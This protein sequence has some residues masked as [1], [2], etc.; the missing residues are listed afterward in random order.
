MKVTGHKTEAVYRRYAIV[1]E[2]D[3]RDAG[4]KLTAVLGTTPESG[5]LNSGDNSVAAR[6]A[7]RLNGWQEWWA[8]TGLNRRHQDFQSCALPTELPAH[9]T[10]QDS[11]GVRDCLFDGRDDADRPALLEDERD[12]DDLAGLERARERREHDAPAVRLEPDELPA[13]HLELAERRARRPDELRAPGDRRLDPREHVAELPGVVELGVEHGPI[14]VP[15]EPP[16]GRLDADAAD[17]R[18]AGVIDA[19]AERERAQDQDRAAGAAPRHAPLKAP[20]ATRSDRRLDP[21]EHVAEL[22]GVVELGVEHG[23]IPVP[24]EPPV[25][26]L[27]ADAADLR[28]AGVIDAGAERERAQDQ[29]RAAGAAPRHAPLKAPSATIARNAC[30]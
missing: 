5:P 18:D 27:D 13:R 10:R 7:R 26:R 29:D 8:G 12:D 15:D 23:P 3:L 9:Q 25:G 21:R 4:S 19:G 2:S 14:P 28:D 6:K 22:P 24:D 16:V 20:S 17:L 11:K 1:V 30:S